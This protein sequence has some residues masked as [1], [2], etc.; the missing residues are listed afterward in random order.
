MP[1][2]CARLFP[3]STFYHLKHVQTQE[4]R[5]GTSDTTAHRHTTCIGPH[6]LKMRRC[7]KT[8]DRNTQCNFWPLVTD[9]SQSRTL[10]TRAYSISW[11]FSYSL[12][13][14]LR[15]QVWPSLTPCS[16]ASCIIQSALLDHQCASKNCP[17]T[18]K[19]IIAFILHVSKTRVS[20]Q[21]SSAFRVFSTIFILGLH[22]SC[23]AMSY[24]R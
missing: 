2:F 24:A 13:S 4:I 15:P 3:T 6:W 8:F 20:Q 11:C 5:N 18:S 21:P 1:H 7:V 17:Y 16:P 12:S 9:Q 22:L 10:F 23:N 19:Q 14:P